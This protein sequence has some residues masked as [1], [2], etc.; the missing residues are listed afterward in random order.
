[1][2]VLLDR[3]EPST[4]GMVFTS[5]E[6]DIATSEARPDWLP[7]AFAT[8]EAIGKALGTGLA[9]LDWTDIEALPQDPGAISVLLHGR[10]AERAR[11]LGV[12]EWRCTWTRERNDHLFVVAIAKEADGELDH[13]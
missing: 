7:L 11:E 8:K 1:M 4:L 12:R 9:R 5:A 10:A 6:R 13:Q 2:R 3:Y